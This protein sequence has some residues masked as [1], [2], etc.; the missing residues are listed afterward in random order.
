MKGKPMERDKS[1]KVVIRRPGPARSRLEAL[2]YAGFHPCPN[3]GRAVRPSVSHPADEGMG[4]HWEVAVD[5]HNCGTI[6]RYIF[7]E[8]PGWPGGREARGGPDRTADPSAR[9]PHLAVSPVRTLLFTPDELLALRDRGMVVLDKLEGRKTGPE[10]P[11]DALKGLL[12]AQAL[13]MLRPMLELERFVADGDAVL[14]EGHRALRDRLAA[15]ARAT[16]I[17]VP[18]IEV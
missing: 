10:G 11:D 15:H 7:D 12:A 3:C 17:E 9:T 4:G 2:T 16:G 6:T 1:L 14:P 8:G 13:E 5:C 18:G